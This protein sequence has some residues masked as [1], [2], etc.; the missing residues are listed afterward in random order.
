MEGLHAVVRRAP[1][2]SYR[3]AEPHKALD[4]YPD[5]F[6]HA[7]DLPLIAQHTWLDLLSGADLFLRETVERKLAE[8]RVELEGANPSPLAKLL[9]ER[10]VACWLQLNHL[11]TVFAGNQFSSEAIRN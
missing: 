5:Y 2:G 6:S 1:G 7:G 10:V 3:A 8:I 11:D 9:V 4:K